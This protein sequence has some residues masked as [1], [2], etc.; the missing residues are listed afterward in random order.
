MNYFEILAALGEGAAHPGGFA[1]TLRLLNE[2]P[3]PK[4]ARILEVGCG[5][6]RTACHMAQ[7]GYQVS[8]IDLN[9]VMIEKAIQ[10]ADLLDVKVDFQEADTVALFFDSAQ[11]DVVFVESVT[12]FVDIPKALKEFYRVLKRGGHL[13]DREIY[14]TNLLPEL[15]MIM[16]GLYG[17]VHIPSLDEWI[18]FFETAGFKD[19]GLWNVLNMKEHPFHPDNQNIDIDPLQMQMIDME[20]FYNPS[21]IHFVQRNQDFFEKYW[22]YLSYSVFIGERS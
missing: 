9:P 1:S 12:L 20:V 14:K 15:S 5:T 3:I 22:S 21:V 11:F 17:N 7:L 6:G 19:V 16:R 2:H 18:F 8:A 10:R 13:Y 4:E